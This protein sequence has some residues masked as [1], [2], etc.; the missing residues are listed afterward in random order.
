MLNVSVV[1]NMQ[2]TLGEGITWDTRSESFWFVDIHEQKVFQYS[3]DEANLTTWLIQQRIGWLIPC[4]ESA[5]WIGG[6]QEGFARLRFDKEVHLEWIARPFRNQPH[7]RLNDAKAD[8]SGNIWAG[9]V[10]NDNESLPDGVLFKLTPGGN[11]TVI[12]SGYCVSNGPAISPC[13]RLFLHSDSA[14]RTIYAFDFEITS[15]S[16]S[17]KRIWRIFSQEEG[18]PDGMNFDMHG[19]LW[20]AHWGS[21]LISCF[22]QDAVLLQRIKLPVSNVT[23]LTFGGKQLD[24]LF[25]TTARCGLSATSL[26]TE[27]L[28]GSV[29]EIHN[30]GSKGIPANCF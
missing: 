30:H 8:R 16:F 4:T 24:R 29:F 17:N 14:K 23:N 2:R 1:L 7:M 9:S 10:H 22:N 11:L 13:N 18:Y 15:A 12:D 19:N 26:A 6:L 5:D 27:P 3:P 21:G 28:A 20:V 25:A